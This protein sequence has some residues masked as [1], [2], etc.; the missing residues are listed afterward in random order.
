MFNV[1]DVSGGLTIALAVVT[2]VL[3]LTRPAVSTQP[4]IGWVGRALQLEARF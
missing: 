2:T 4:T 3:V 1:A